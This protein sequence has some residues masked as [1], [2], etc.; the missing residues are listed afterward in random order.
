MRGR[1]EEQEVMFGLRES[2]GAGTQGPSPTGQQSG[3]RRG[4]ETSLF[5]LR[6]VTTHVARRTHS[7]IDGRTTRHTSY[8]ASQK[9]RAHV[10]A[11]T[12]RESG[13]SVNRMGTCARGLHVCAGTSYERLQVVAT[14]EHVDETGRRGMAHAG[15]EYCSLQPMC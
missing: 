12:L 8:R 11:G 1:G 10:V 3:G 5:P 15:R 6:G 7:A 9:V 14:G 2:G 13:A 4:A